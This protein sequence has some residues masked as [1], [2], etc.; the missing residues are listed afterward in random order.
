MR[1][2]VLPCHSL[3]VAG[4]LFTKQLQEQITV[5]KQRLQVLRNTH[6]RP[7]GG[8]AKGPGLQLGRQPQRQ[9][10]RSGEAQGSKG[11]RGCL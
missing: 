2:Y 7:I 3:L 1:R 10:R 11:A 9:K 6:K 4:V 5:L 8:V